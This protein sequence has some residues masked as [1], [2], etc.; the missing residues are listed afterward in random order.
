MAVKVVAEHQDFTYPDGAVW[1]VGADG[2]MAVYESGGVNRI[3]T[4]ASGEWVA[5]MK[6]PEGDGNA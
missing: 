1:S 5:V 3:A 2:T 4:H 6:C